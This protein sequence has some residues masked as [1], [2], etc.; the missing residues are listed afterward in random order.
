MLHW[1]QGCLHK[2]TFLIK[3]K[4]V[5]CSVQVAVFLCHVWDLFPVQVLQQPVGCC[6]GRRKRTGHKPCALQECLLAFRPHGTRGGA[7]IAP[8]R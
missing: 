6:W 4:K 8:D 2:A 3:L 1:A 7:I 5:Y